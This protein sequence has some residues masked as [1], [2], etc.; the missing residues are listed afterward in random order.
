M[1]YIHILV[2]VDKILDEHFLD[3]VGDILEE[4][5]HVVF[6]MEVAVH[7][8]VEKLHDDADLVDGLGEEFWGEVSAEPSSDDP[9]VL[10]VEVKG[11]F[12]D[13]LIEHSELHLK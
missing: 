4:A 1:N 5:G 12:V 10:L 13:K 2:I 6:L 8:E 11:V 9:V 7:P 3:E